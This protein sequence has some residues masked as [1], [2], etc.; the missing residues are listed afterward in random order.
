MDNQSFSKKFGEN[1]AKGL[2]VLENDNKLV[3]L[4]YRTSFDYNNNRDMAAKNL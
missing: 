4:V 1:S 2:K 3:Y